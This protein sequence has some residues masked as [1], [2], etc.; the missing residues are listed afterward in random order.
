M[1]CSNKDCPLETIQ[2]LTCIRPEAIQR[3][4]PENGRLPLHEACYSGASVEVVRFLVEA[5]PQSIRVGNC[6][7]MLPLHGACGAAPRL[8]T[9]QY[10]LQTYPE[11]ARIRDTGRGRFLPL[12]WCCRNRTTSPM[13][14]NVLLEAYPESIRERTHVGELPFHLVAGLG[15]TT[16]NR[17]A[18][19]FILRLL[20]QRYPEAMQESQKTARLPS[21]FSW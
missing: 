6:E 11:S 2:Y 20:G 19:A 16:H 18:Q 7:G 17:V 14:Y 8:E 3:K 12:H 1:A 15:P 21:Q 5:W 10:L 4:A 13:V 9:I